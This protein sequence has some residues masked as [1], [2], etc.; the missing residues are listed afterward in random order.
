MQC[1]NRNFPYSCIAACVYILTSSRSAT[2]AKCEPGLIMLKCIWL[3]V[4]I[5]AVF[6]Y[7]WIMWE[8]AIQSKVTQ[9]RLDPKLDEERKNK[10]W[11]LDFYFVC[12][13]YCCWSLYHV[14]FSSCQGQHHSLE[15]ERE[16]VMPCNNIHN[17]LL[18]LIMY[19]N[20][21]WLWHV[22]CLM[23]SV[24]RKKRNGVNDPSVNWFPLILNLAITQ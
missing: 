8:S 13:M 16:N 7:P 22:R 15:L 5:A 2:Q 10:K 6:V 18:L 19:L 23:C 3:I 20:H 21:S 4:L 17:V 24:C 9:H 12:C 14:Y 11:L 1:R